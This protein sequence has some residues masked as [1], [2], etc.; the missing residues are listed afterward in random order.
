MFREG[1]TFGR[2]I[3]ATCFSGIISAEK[4][5]MEA[6]EDMNTLLSKSIVRLE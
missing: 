4:R 5:V 1:T 3:P 2:N 6:Y